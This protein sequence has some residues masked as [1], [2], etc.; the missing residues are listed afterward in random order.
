[1]VGVE[2]RL[3]LTVHADT[4]L[5]CDPYEVHVIVLV[6]IQFA[7]L[8]KVKFRRRLPVCRVINIRCSVFQIDFRIHTLHQ[9]CEGLCVS[10][11][12]GLSIRQSADMVSFPVADDTVCQSCRRLIHID[13]DRLVRRHVS[14]IRNLSIH[15]CSVSLF[16]RCLSLFGSKESVY[17]L[18]NLD[19]DIFSSQIF[20]DICSRI[21]SDCLGILGHICLCLSCC[22]LL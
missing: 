15:N 17:L 14:E 13:L 18:I 10:H 7:V 4:G 9:I 3:R 11:A 20:N 22:L 1:M 16:N 5:E 19:S 8:I 6:N 12:Y 21:R 2:I